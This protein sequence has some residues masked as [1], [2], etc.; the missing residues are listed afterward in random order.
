[1][2]GTAVKIFLQF[3]SM[4]NGVMITEKYYVTGV[5]KMIISVEIVSCISKKDF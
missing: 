3:L 1:M 2:F 4:A 5:R